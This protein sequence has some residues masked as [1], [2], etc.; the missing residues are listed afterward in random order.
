MITRDELLREL[1]VSG[2]VLVITKNKTFDI[3]G[4]EIPFVIS[5]AMGR[6]VEDIDAKIIRIKMPTD[7]KILRYYEEGRTDEQDKL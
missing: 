5:E 3:D 1:A 2:E 7:P 6:I 4:N